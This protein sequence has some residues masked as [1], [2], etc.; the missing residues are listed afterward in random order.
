MKNKI[1][2]IFL[3]ALTA[4]ALF[5]SM[6]GC[7]LE[8]ESWNTLEEYN[9]EEFI[10]NVRTKKDKTK[11]GYLM[12]LTE[13]GEQQKE[14]ILSKEFRNIPIVNFGY[15]RP[16]YMGE[17]Y[18]GDL[19][20]SILEKLYVPFSVDENTWDFIRNVH[21][22]NA[23]AVQ[24]KK[25]S[26]IITIGKGLVLGYPVYSEILKGSNRDRLTYMVYIL[27]YKLYLAN[28]S[29][30]LNYETAENDGYYW[31]D[32]YDKCLIDFIPPKPTREGYK[33]AGWYKEAE[34]LNKWDFETDKTVDELLID[35]DKIITNQNMEVI[36]VI[37]QYTEYDGIKLF[38]K[39]EKE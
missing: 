31:V 9:S 15:N 39:W 6:T 22:L 26:E 30:M 17:G 7:G 13:Y 24:W 10:Y 8:I 18:Y 28:V 32:S 29:Y 38:A 19:R 11:E 37:A 4:V 5:L 34:C 23:R 36:E 14:L 3:A 27:S 35:R 33:F 16:S 25:F 1:M 20:S 21:C 2:S 12:G